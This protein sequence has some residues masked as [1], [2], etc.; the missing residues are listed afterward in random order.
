MFLRVLEQLPTMRDLEH[1]EWIH[2]EVVV[3]GRTDIH[4]GILVTDVQCSR[5]FHS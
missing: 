2:Q 5:R 3:I 1:E 4:P